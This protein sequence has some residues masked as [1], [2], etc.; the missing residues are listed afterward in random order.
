MFI[1]FNLFDVTLQIFDPALAKK[2][3]KKKKTTFDSELILDETAEAPNIESEDA[4]KD[5]GASGEA[6]FDDN[7]DLESFGKKKKKKKKG[8]LELDENTIT[9]ASDKNS[10]DQDENEGGVEGAE[11]G[12]FNLDVDFSMT[13]KKKKKNKKDVLDDLLEKDQLSKEDDKENGK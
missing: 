8:F 13:K 4:T 3:P 9:V 11:E 5:V 2:K 7:M 6:D 1:A 10:G 12:D